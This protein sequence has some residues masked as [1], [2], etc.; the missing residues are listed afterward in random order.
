MAREGYHQFRDGQPSD[1]Q[2]Q[3]L[4]LLAEGKTNAEIADRLGITAD[5]V[6]WHISELLGETGLADRQALARWWVEERAQRR[7]PAFLPLWPPLPRVAIGSSAAAVVLVIVTG[8]LLWGQGSGD[9][10]HLPL[11]EAAS[12][13]VAPSPTP[14]PQRAIEA[15]PPPPCDTPVPGGFRIV[16][17]EEL[18]GEG[19]VE[20]GRII[21]PLSCPMQVSN[22]ADLAFL[23]LADGGEIE[24]EKAGLHGVSR[25]EFPS[26]WVGGGNYGP[27][28]LGFYHEGEQFR[29]SMWVFDEGQSVITQIEGWDIVLQRTGAAGAFASVSLEGESRGRL[30]VAFA[31]DGTLFFDPEPLPGSLATN[32]ITGETIDVSRMIALGRFDLTPVGYPT[33][34]WT[35]CSETRGVCSVGL[36]AVGQPIRMPVG[37]VLTCVPVMSA[38]IQRE[39]YELDTGEYV[40]RFTP[41]GGYGV[42]WDGACATMSAWR[43][44]LSHAIAPG[45]EVYTWTYTSIEAFAADGSPVSVV[46]ARDGHLFVGEVRL[47]V[48]CPCRSGH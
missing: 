6:K 14:T 45:D 44:S 2:R 15:G 32:S 26:G 38:G 35:A 23:W 46:I 29:V 20:F 7:Q 19:L 12:A 17:A 16:T 33:D 37:G 9:G 42:P 11:P 36:P 8:W 22:R 47:K 34:P 1:R 39:G 10:E 21:E 27:G 41:A 25:W 18:R 5:G 28:N 13:D 48:G 43:Q 24:A 3:V 4:D 31:S 30:Q 40:L